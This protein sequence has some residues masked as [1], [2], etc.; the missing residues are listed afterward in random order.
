MTE[1][2]KD[3]KK[4]IPFYP[5]HFMNEV[6]VV[7]WIVGIVILIGISAFFF[8]VGLEEPANDMV[9]P[10][11]V[12]PEWYFLGF[13]QILKFIPKT[14]G[15]LLLVGFVLVLLVWPFFDRKADTKTQYKI[16]LFGGLGFIIIYAALTIW[17][18]VV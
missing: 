3:T 18:M 2:T 11:H 10:E 5:D 13:Y 1:E 17:G 16:R 8:P 15:V 4:P 6:R 7:W 9:T 12:K 14:A